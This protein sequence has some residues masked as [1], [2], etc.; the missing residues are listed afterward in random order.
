[1]KAVAEH[2]H[3]KPHHPHW[4]LAV[5]LFSFVFALTVLSVRDPSTWIRI[6]VGAKILSDGILPRTETF[7]YGAAGARWTTHSWLAD[8][9]FAKLDALGGPGLVGALT[10]AAIAGAFALMLPISHG[11]PMIAASL[12]SVGAC[13]AWAG[14]AATPAAFDFLFFALFVRLLRPRRRFRWT[15]AAAAAGLTALWSNL[16][17]ASAPLAAWLVGLKVFKASLRTVARERLGYWIMMVACAIAFSWNPHGY[18]LLEHF[19]S[20]AASG[21]AAWRAPLA[22]LYG[23]LLVAGL[24]SCWFTLQQEFVT[25]LAAATILGL[26]VVLPGLRPLAAL[27]AC[28]VAALALGHAVKPRGDTR[29]RVLLWCA[30]AAVLLA[31]Y[32][33]TITRPLARS[34]GY[35]APALAG[36]VHFL[37]ASGV[38]GRMFNEPETGSELIGSTGRPVF[39]DLRQ[40]LYPASFRR[41]AADWARIFPSLDAI[42]RFDY[43]VV[44]N[45]RAAAPARVLD[46]DPD[47]RLAY[48]DDRALVYLKKSGVNAWLAPQSPFRRL[49]PNR[50]W[51]DALDAALADPRE[52]PRILEELDRWRISAPDCDQALLWKAYAL[53]RL[54]MGAQADR[55]VDLAR[56]RPASEW[57]PELQALEAYVLESRGRVDEARLLYL[58][59]ERAARRL[60]APA[61]A[62]AAAERRR[63]LG[64]R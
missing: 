59:A 19:F 15:D 24:A 6:R 25:T 8:V 37:D 51:P 34:G 13:A 40:T 1:M 35:G 20:D 4:P 29:P 30:L 11:N 63:G 53:S 3:E 28:P 57:D 12:L 39:S 23:L 44:R 61:L 64:P 21:S 17:G 41:D 5:L 42:Y 38:R 7:S 27:A 26:S 50:L 32:A 43:A 45:R 48:A 46:G 18:G 2:P 58:R 56:G 33:Q 52:A 16:H 9:A 14:F 60:D 47:W 49:T 55:L 10:G 36:A 54:K 31:A 62:A 22:S